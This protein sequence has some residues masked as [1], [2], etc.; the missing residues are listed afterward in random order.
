ML[1]PNWTGGKSG[2]REKAGRGF[3]PCPGTKKKYS[4]RNEHNSGTT[5]ARMLVL[6][7]NERY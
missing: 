6:E 7:S 4:C 5:Q 3:K 2:E 1:R